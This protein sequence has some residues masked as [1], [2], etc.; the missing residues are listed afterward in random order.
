MEI[1]GGNGQIDV[2]VRT[3]LAS[4]SKIKTVKYS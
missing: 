3:F 1:V 4:S 2:V